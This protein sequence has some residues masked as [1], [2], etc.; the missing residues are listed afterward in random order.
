VVNFHIVFH[1]VLKTYPSCAVENVM[2]L[3]D[4]YEKYGFKPF[5]CRS[6]ML[7]TLLNRLKRLLKGV[8]KLWQTV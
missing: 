2:F 8:I 1:T 6:K 5:V 3:V 7:K 4:F